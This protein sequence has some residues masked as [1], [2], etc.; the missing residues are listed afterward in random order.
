MDQ[1]RLVELALMS[2]HRDINI[3]V[4]E[5]INTFSANNRK[6]KIN[7]NLYVQMYLLNFF[8]KHAIL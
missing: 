1:E 8:Y 4:G 5:V 7:I 6:N 2:V 3:D